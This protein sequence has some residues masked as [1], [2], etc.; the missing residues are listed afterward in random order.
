V[1]A[2]IRPQ[3]AVMGPPSG[4]YSRQ[5]REGRGDDRQALL[6]DWEAQQARCPQWHPSV[7][8][9]PGPDVSGDPI[10]RSQFDGATWHACPARPACPAA[11]DA[12]RQLTVRLPVH[13]EA[14]QASRQRQET[15]AFQ[16]QYALRGGIESRLSHRSRRFHLRRSRY[17]GLA[18]THLQQLFN[19]TALNVVRVTA[20]L[21]G[22]PLGE[23]R[24]QPG[25]VAPLA[26]HPLS[27]QMVRCEGMMRPKARRVH[28]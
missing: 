15:A 20:W 12:P 11:Q 25:H 18:R 7:R 5:R 17:L 8:W 23:R 22:E 16:T 6:I 1:T 13:H 28:A 26:A 24:R 14:L 4:S 9:R 10:I 21:R 2:Q 3:I 27:R 19:A